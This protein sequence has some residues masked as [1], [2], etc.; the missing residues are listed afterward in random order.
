MSYKLYVCLIISV[1]MVVGCNG[2]SC[3]TA[4]GDVI[5]QCVGGQGA[6]AMQNCLDATSKANSVCGRNDLTPIKVMEEAM[7]NANKK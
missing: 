6:V 7:Q 4:K 1:L 3:E 2:Q 5:S